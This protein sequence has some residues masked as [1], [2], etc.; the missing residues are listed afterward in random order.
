MENWV[1]QFS[2]VY[3]DVVTFLSKPAARTLQTN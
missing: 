2:G 3:I 1:S